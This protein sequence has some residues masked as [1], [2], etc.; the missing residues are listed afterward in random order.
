MLAYVK[1][2]LP[3]VIIN[4]T[5]FIGERYILSSQNIMVEE[6]VARI[7]KNNDRPMPR[8]AIP[9]PLVFMISVFSEVPILVLKQPK[10]LAPLIGTELKR[11]GTQH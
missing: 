6:L 7:K 10:P 2:G 8:L 1:E 4:P 9:F 3:A 5:M 11:H